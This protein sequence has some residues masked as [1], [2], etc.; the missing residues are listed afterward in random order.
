[1]Y[2]IQLQHVQHK[3]TTCTAYNYKMYNI[4]LQHV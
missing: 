2:N 3:I 4:Q 1:M